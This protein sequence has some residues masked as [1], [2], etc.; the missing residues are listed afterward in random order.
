M[1]NYTATMSRANANTRTAREIP[2]T[3]AREIIK[4]VVEGSAALQLGRTFRMPA[5]QHRIRVLAALADAYWLHGDSTDTRGNPGTGTG[6]QADKDS[7]VKSRTKLEWDNVYVTPE[8]IAV[9]VPI[10]DAWMAD[11]DISWGEIRQEIVRAIARKIDQGVFFGAGNVPST[12]GPGLIPAAISKGMYVVEGTGEAEGDRDQ[13]NDLSLD[14]ATLGELLDSKG[15]DLS[16]YA[17]YRSFKWRLRKLRDADGQPI[18]FERDGRFALYGE[19]M[20]EVG[21]GSWD[22]TQATLLGGEWDKLVIGIRQDITFDVFDQAVL[23]DPTTGAV[24]YNSVEQDGKV[25]RAVM[26]IGYAVPNPVKVLGG[27]FPFAVL[28]PTD[29]SE[30]S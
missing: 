6:T 3:V 17:T 18:L 25:L 12:F 10:P 14:I 9:L 22:K 26:R 8:E 11:S 21:N 30:S 28:T 16:G 5:Y 15:Y 13:G 19:P 4:D 23:T 20:R 24:V 29:P 27:E 7:A 2:E 1:T